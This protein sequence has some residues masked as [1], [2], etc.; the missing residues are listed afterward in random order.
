MSVESAARNKQVWD[1]AEHALRAGFMPTIC[2]FNTNF[3]RENNRQRAWQHFNGVA[4][5][6]MDSGEWV[7]LR[8]LCR[9]PPAI[10]E[11]SAELRRLREV[12][13]RS[14]R[15]VDSFDRF[16]EFYANYAS[17]KGAPL[18]DVGL[19]LLGRYHT[20][21]SLLPSRRFDTVIN[22]G[23]GDGVFDL[24]LIENLSPREYMMCDLS[25]IRDVSERLTSLS[26]NTRVK[27]HQVR[28]SITDWPGGTYDLVVA[29]EILEHVPDQELFLKCA[30]ER[31][32]PGGVLL[33]STPD[34]AVWVSPTEV[35]ETTRLPE[36]ITANTAH[37][38]GEKIRSLVPAPSVAKIAISAESHL[39]ALVE[40][41][42]V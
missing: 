30:W 16:K 20:A 2:N 39:V 28:E 23:C 38:L 29:T 31:V 7:T 17:S 6:L 25:D 19:N 13:E 42:L 34:A 10:L 41:P 15:H 36:H 27:V 1:T 21:L 18:G 37:T 26:P 35:V 3:I 40:K 8:A 9:H 22:L 14:T 12:V 11:G 5:F 32:A 24:R 4:S 33:L